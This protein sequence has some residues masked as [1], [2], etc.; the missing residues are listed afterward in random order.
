M[1]PSFPI[2]ASTFSP[3]V[4]LLFCVSDSDGGGHAE[5]AGSGFQGALL[6][7]ILRVLASSKGACWLE[8]VF[9][10]SFPLSCEPTIIY[11]RNK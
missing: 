6:N 1:K 2:K 3:P 8:S 5:E 11:G 10:A 9:K 7:F 4:R